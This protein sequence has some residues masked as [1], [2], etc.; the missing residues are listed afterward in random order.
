MISVAVLLAAAAAGPSLVQG[1]EPESLLAVAGRLSE[2][3][4][5]VEARAR[6]LD[7]RDAIAELFARSAREAADTPLVMARRLAE[8]YALAWRDS[9]FVREVARF[10]A[11]PDQRRTRKVRADSIRRAGNVAYGQDGPA[12]AIEIWRRALSLSLRI[13]DSSGIAGALGNIGAGMLESQ[14]LDSAE[15][16]LTRSREIAAAIGDA[17]TEGNAVGLLAAVSEALGDF[18]QARPRYQAALRL[19]ERTGDTR[20]V[21]A[22][23]NNLGLLAQA[24]DDLDGARTHFEAALALNRA[25]GRDDLIATNLVNLAGLA[26]L[27]GDFSRASALYGDALA[28]WRAR[29][30]MA[31]AAPALHGLG[32]LELRRGQYAAARQSLREAFATYK[33]AGRYAEAV[34]VQRDLSAAHAAS[35]DMQRARDALRDAAHLADSMSLPPAARAGVALSLGD[36]ALETNDFAEA[37]RRF[38]LAEELYAVGADPAGVAS[39]RHGRGMLLLERQDYAGAQRVLTAALTIQLSDEDT[40][41]AA[42]TR[43][44]IAGVL[45]ARGD[46]IAARR[47]LDHARAMF[48][49][50]GDPV[51]GA[52]AT[53]YLADLEAAS[54]AVATA[55]ALYRA[56]IGQLQTRP[57]THVSW[58]LRTGLAL[59]LRS[60]GNLDAS[61]RLL[62]LAI[63]DI[64]RSARGIAIPERRSAFLSDKWEPYAELAS[65]EISRGRPGIA[66]EVSE[67]LRARGMLELLGYGRLDAASDADPGLVGREQDLRHRISELT[68]ELAVTVAGR[69]P[70]RGPNLPLSDSRRLGDL[71]D[72]QAAYADLLL[73]IRERAPRHASLIS[74]QV[75]TWREVARHLGAGQALVEY[76]VS[77]SGSLAFV[78]TRD[79]I[80]AVDLGIESL[81]LRRLVSFA[82]ATLE[83]RPTRSDSLWRT[84]MRRLRGYLIA[85]LLES[86]A[87]RGMSRLVIVPHLELHYLP[88]AALVNHS[89]MA[90]TR[91][92][93]LTLA[94]SASV[95]L[96]IRARPR[97]PATGI[98]TLAP[99]SDELT[100]T[101]LEA[102]AIDR[103]SGGRARVLV[104]AAATEEVF[105]REAPSRQIIHVASVGVLNKHNPLFSFVELGAGGSHD[106][107]LDVHEV[108]GLQ[109][110][111]DLVVLAACQTALASGA[112]RDVPPGDDWIGFT[113]AFLHAGASAVLGTLWPVDDWA[114]AVFMERFYEALASGSGPAAALSTAQRSLRDAPATRHPF[115]WAGFVLVGAER[116]IQALRDPGDA[117][118]GEA[119]SN[120]KGAFRLTGRGNTAV[121]ETRNDR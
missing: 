60:R 11:S 43:L 9:L 121:K 111:A 79:T 34:D 68:N 89:G 63:E 66:F 8:A 12:A 80:T 44:S 32:Q 97:R 62:R 19:R 3:A 10:A 103:L 25:D 73:E 92:Y 82:R 120:Q 50:V 45:L 51:G 74:H 46:T 33:R 27:E 93:D 69:A 91:E 53:A 70:V 108:F 75:V 110:S 98:L 113:R 105:R 29:D 102:A 81:E 96:A 119:T 26:S 87:L 64:E 18:E 55:E 54:G 42:I 114:T 118:A 52:A 61:A 49:E 57:A 48:R 88:F 6:P 37:D 16:Y 39:A 107:R 35:G 84:A 115:F 31:E 94:P 106:G 47:E 21:A 30:L 2:S 24:M 117:N 59:L 65:V 86:G 109:L 22:D 67:R 99:R 85:P 20:G 71:L 5:V 4:L 36:L 90:L 104:G 28:T 112:L 77:D 38:A 1:Q 14:Q 100:G 83:S 17:R 13:A 76:L 95:W 7:F 40:R 41:A 15:S 101:R 116:E 78:V 56:G 72:A 23:H 58:R